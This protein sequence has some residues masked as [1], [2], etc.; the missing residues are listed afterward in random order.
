MPDHKKLYTEDGSMHH[1]AFR[2]LM[3]EISNPRLL[4]KWCK[5]QNLKGYWFYDWN[6]SKPEGGLLH[7]VTFSFE[8]VEQANHFYE[9]WKDYI[10]RDDDKLPW[11]DPNSNP[12]VYA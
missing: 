3:K 1:A 2:I 6:A 10:E 4:S 7:W 5:E 8:T 9:T 11:P 12:G